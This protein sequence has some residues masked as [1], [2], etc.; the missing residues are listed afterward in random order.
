MTASISQWSLIL[1]TSFYYARS[2]AAT[3]SVEEEKSISFHSDEYWIP[4]YLV[5]DIAV[6][7]SIIKVRIFIIFNYNCAIHLIM[8]I[9]NM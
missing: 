8:F 7:L 6:I 1:G 5:N 9:I 3:S 2:S 4:E